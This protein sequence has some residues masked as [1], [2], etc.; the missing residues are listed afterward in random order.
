MHGKALSPI[1]GTCQVCI[2]TATVFLLTSWEPKCSD[3]RP[4]PGY[5]PG[6]EDGSQFI[7]GSVGLMSNLHFP[8]GTIEWQELEGTAA[9]MSPVSVCTEAD[10]APQREKR[11]EANSWLDQAKSKVRTVPGA[12]CP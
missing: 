2:L 4:Q 10:T 3:S 11:S 5:R 12:H 6:Q 8:W 9:M 7:P 1:P